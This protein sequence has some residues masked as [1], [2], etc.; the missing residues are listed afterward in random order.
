MGCRMYLST[1]EFFELC[2]KQLDEVELKIH[3][4]HRM[5]QE[6][7]AALDRISRML[8]EQINGNQDDMDGGGLNQSSQAEHHLHAVYTSSTA[9]PMH[10][11]SLQSEALRLVK[12]RSGDKDLPT[13][14]ELRHPLVFNWGTPFPEW[15]TCRARW[16]LPSAR[17]INQSTIQRKLTSLAWAVHYP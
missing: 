5:I 3:E 15:R 8:D 2:H 7:N 9:C 13:S 14:L 16:N 12:A 4:L 10:L 1:E 11:S 17:P 6:T